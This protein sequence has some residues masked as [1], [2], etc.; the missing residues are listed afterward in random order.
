METAYDRLEWQ[1]IQKC[2][3]KLGFR[4]MDNWIMEYMTTMSLSMLI[5]FQ[6]ILL[7]WKDISDRLIRF[8]Y[9]LL[10]FMSNTSVDILVISQVV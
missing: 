8:P 4:E 10:L 1:F 3:T 6:V 7:S 2:F 5:I 9:I